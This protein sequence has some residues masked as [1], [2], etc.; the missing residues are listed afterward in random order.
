MSNL[1]TA[2]T[3]VLAINVMFIL[4]QVAVT[5][6]SGSEATFYN[7]SG[8]IHSELGS[9]GGD[10][11]LNTGGSVALLPDADATSVSE[12]T[13]NVFTDAFTGIKSWFLESTGLSYVT[14]ILSTPYNIILSLGLP[15]AFAF[16]VGGLWY[17]VTLFLLIA[18][19]FGRND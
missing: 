18:F 1:T 13:G 10:Y 12:E 2:L 16:A 15:P 5:E 19:L 7:C 14:Q 9:C 11:A 8:T 3:I 4:G 6:V 17:G